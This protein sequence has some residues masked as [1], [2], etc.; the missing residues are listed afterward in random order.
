MESGT[1]TAFK[2]SENNID[3]IY[4][5]M[6]GV[7]CD[8]M[9]ASCDLLGVYWPDLLHFW[10][11]NYRGEWKKAK[12][13]S[14]FTGKKI[15]RSNID[16]NINEA[17]QKFWEKLDKFGHSDSLLFKAIELVGKESVF[18][19]TSPMTS[20][21]GCSQ[22]K[23]NWLHNWFKKLG[24]KGMDRNFIITFHKHLLSRPGALLIDDSENQVE[25]F[26]NYILVD[27]PWNHGGV[28]HKEISQTLEGEFSYG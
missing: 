13:I 22:G 21:Q 28:D 9:G 23:I 19:L 8:W 5:D 18:I 10:N 17:G 16:K 12:V 25:G 26:D 24:I 4:I 20:V 15:K 11:L 2:N 6:D 27:R 7:L 14:D 3:T 1:L